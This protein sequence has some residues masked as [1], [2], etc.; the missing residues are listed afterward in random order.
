VVVSAVSFESVA[1]SRDVD[2]VEGSA[3]RST[4]GEAVSAGGVWTSAMFG[5]C[6]GERYVV[7]LVLA[8]EF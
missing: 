8:I 3:V 5:E 2:V 1:G 4:V 6:G 7:D